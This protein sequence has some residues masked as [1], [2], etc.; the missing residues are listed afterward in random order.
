[1][2][3]GLRRFPS[4]SPVWPVGPSDRWH[5]Y[6]LRMVVR[7][8]VC[9]AD[10]PCTLH[11]QHR[12]ECTSRKSHMHYERARDARQD[13][14]TRLYRRC[15]RHAGVRRAEVCECDSHNPRTGKRYRSCLPNCGWV[16]S[17]LLFCRR[18]SKTVVT[19]VHHQLK[20]KG[21][22]ALVRQAGRW[23]RSQQNWMKHIL[24]RIQLIKVVILPIHQS[25]QLLREFFAG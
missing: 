21:L 16:N 3:A 18:P 13:E 9:S 25:L 1:M 15:M 17:I 24:W 7:E 19:S 4:T 8:C 6:K 10:T 12:R 23:P 20:N 14:T 2:T 11:D 5:L 22:K